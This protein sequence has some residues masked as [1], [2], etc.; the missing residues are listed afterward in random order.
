MDFAL[1]FRFTERIDLENLYVHRTLCI[2][3]SSINKDMNPLVAKRGGVSFRSWFIDPEKAYMMYA[4][5]VH[6]VKDTNPRLANPLALDFALGFRF[7]RIGRE[8]VY[9]T[10]YSIIF[11][12]DQDHLHDVRKKQASARSLPTKKC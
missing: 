10:R 1:G 4:N 11:A 3:R 2:L 6:A 9:I 7:E 5:E 12:V 8:K